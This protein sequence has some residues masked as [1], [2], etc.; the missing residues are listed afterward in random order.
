MSLRCALSVGLPHIRE[1][2]RDES[3]W[4]IAIAAI[5]LAAAII[6]AI[7]TAGASLVVAGTAIAVGAGGYQLSQSVQNY[8]AESAAS[9]VALDANI[10]DFSVN[11][12]EMLPIAL[13][14]VGLGLDAFD[15]V[16]VAKLLKGSVRAART[17]RSAE[18]LH[19][20]LTSMRAAAAG[21]GISEA[22]ALRLANRVAREADIEASMVRLIEGV[23]G[24]I[25]KADLDDVVLQIE[26]MS[27]DAV[28]AAVAELR[29]QDR[30]FEL[31]EEGLEAAFRDPDVVE[32]LIT[33]GWLRWGGMYDPHTGYVFVRAGSQDEF[34][35]LLVHET[36]HYVHPN[37]PAGDDQVCGGVR[38]VRRA[39]RIPPA[40]GR[41]RH[42][43]RH[44]VPRLP[45]VARR[46]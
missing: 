36:S 35:S 29:A 18:E 37:L 5:G 41:R 19:G 44:R 30:I 20:A 9:N 13:D 26:R 17:A 12:P 38:S 45:L 22:S 1:E 23:G 40:V 28:S 10:A 16:R 46:V 43:P 6:A 4:N 39:A 21:E 27:D 25:A 34:A 15:V 31:S 2:E 7:P 3:I 14:L 11:D 33:D 42:R 24:R 32:K 8:M